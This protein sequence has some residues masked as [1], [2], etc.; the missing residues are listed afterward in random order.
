VCEEF[1]EVKDKATAVVLIHEIFGWSDWARNAA[2]EVAEAG[3]IAIA[4]NLLSG[5][6]P[7][8]GEKE[9]PNATEAD[10]KPRDAA[11]LRWKDLLKEI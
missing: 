1:P 10:K 3:Y 11:W 6:A 5:R 4:P 9:F 7:N 8:G 2:D